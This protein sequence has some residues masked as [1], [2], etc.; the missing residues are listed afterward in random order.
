MSKALDMILEIDAMRR[1]AREAYF[2]LITDYVRHPTNIA[3]ANFY[4]GKTEGLAMA[5][6]SLYSTLKAEERN[7][8]DAKQRERNEAE[9]S[10]REAGTP[11]PFA[12]ARWN[13]EAST[14][15]SIL[16]SEPYAPAPQ[17]RTD[18]PPS[19]CCP[20]GARDDDGQAS[21]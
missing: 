2:E 11:S 3:E 6:T 7:E 16:R 10:A 8:F 12:K 17:E 1:T 13:A 4:L 5:A 20:S 15:A 21:V 9:T 19:G 18:A 14:V